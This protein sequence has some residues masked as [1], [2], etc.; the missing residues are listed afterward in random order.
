M[1]IEKKKKKKKT[2]SLNLPSFCCIEQIVLIH[3]SKEGER[4]SKPVW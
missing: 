3:D 4:G 1:E 2:H